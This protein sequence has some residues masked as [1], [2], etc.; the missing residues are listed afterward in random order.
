MSNFRTQ[1]SDF[2]FIFTPVLQ[3]V[4]LKFNKSLTP[5][6]VLPLDLLLKG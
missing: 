4:L 1:A 2:E 3:P 5:L 6:L